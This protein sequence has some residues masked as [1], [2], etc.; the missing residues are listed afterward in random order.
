MKDME[1]LQQL[2]AHMGLEQVEIS[3]EDR[4]GTR[5]LH[6]HVRDEDTGMVIG[7]RGE[8]LDALQ[9]VVNLAD[10]V[11]HPVGESEEI[12]RIVVDVNGYRLRREDSVKE[13]AL[14][15]A[16]Q[17]IESGRPMT[18][19]F[20]RASERRIAHMALQDLAGVESRSDG[21]GRERR[22]TIYPKQAE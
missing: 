16:D 1:F 5:T 17:V 22:L 13:M 11:Q 20:L 15:I 21:E 10:R 9:K 12:S 3:E 4:T 18:L 6:V 7:P 2:L 14:D 19:P 8:M